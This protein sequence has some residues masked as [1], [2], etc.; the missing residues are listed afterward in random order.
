MSQINNKLDILISE[1][2]QLQNNR[3]ISTTN[4]IS[5]TLPICNNHNES[6]Y[7]CILESHSSCQKDLLVHRYPKA[8]F[9]PLKK[10]KLNVWQNQHNV[11]K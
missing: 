11:V 7:I 4:E 3:L 8:L 9:F 10:K 6:V 5:S 2:S 1:I